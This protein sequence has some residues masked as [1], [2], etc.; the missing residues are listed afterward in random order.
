MDSITKCH[1]LCLLSGKGSAPME[2]DHRTANGNKLLTGLTH[3]DVVIKAQRHTYF[4]AV[5]NQSDMLFHSFC[6]MEATIQPCPP[7]RNTNGKAYLKNQ[8]TT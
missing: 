3:F 8:Q 6:S 1:D 5:L 4:S 2:S 7:A